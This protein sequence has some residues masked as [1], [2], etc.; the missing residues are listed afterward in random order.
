MELGYTIFD[1]NNDG[2]KDIFISNG[3]YKDLLD[4]DYLNYMANAEQIRAL[5][6]SEEDAITNLVDIMPSNAVENAVFLNQG[7]FDF[8]SAA[9]SIGLG[10]TT[11]SNGAAYGDLDNDGDLDL[12]V[13]NVNMPSS[14]SRI[15]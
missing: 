7:G 8:E 4:R 14:V 9:E 6:Q 13:N 5:I 1:L 10:G 12:V 3:I 11:F 15:I 2:L